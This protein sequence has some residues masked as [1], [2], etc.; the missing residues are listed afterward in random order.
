[1]G[2]GRRSL[3]LRMRH[4][5]PRANRK[6]VGLKTP[7]TA[8]GAKQRKRRQ[9]SSEESEGKEEEE[10]SFEMPVRKKR[11][12]E[13]PAVTQKFTELS[14]LAKDETDSSI[15]FANGEIAQF[16]INYVVAFA[17]HY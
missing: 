6:K 17:I 3:K 12:L 1:M 9:Q 7:K 8:S 5:L 2:I 4:L 15:K 10:V 16:C 13:P 14:A 11:V